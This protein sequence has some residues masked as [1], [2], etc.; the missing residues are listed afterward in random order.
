[1][2]GKPVFD[3]MF[4]YSLDKNILEFGSGSSTID[5]SRITKSLVSVESDKI[6]V[7]ELNKTIDKSKTQIIYANIGPVSTFGTPIRLFK[8]L[9][10]YKYKNYYSKVFEESGINS[11][12]DLII[13]DG[14]F[15]VSCFLNS[16]NNVEPPFIILFDDYF[17]R[18]EYRIIEDF[19]I[20]LLERYDDCA[21]FYVKNDYR[22]QIPSE[23]MNKYKFISA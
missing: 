11:K 18:N 3:L 4:K 7:K 8:C 23:L 19:K 15:R 5:L 2:S 6:L 17:S 13:I 10:K 20:D 22:G 9:Y 1:M 21:V 14:R 16:I 12:F